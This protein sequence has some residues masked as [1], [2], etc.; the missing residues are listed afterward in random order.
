MAHVDPDIAVKAMSE[1]WC[2]FGNE[3]SSPLLSTWKRMCLA[4]NEAGQRSVGWTVLAMPTG[5]GKTQ[6]AA[7]YCAL[8]HNPALS[9]Y[10]FSTI[11]LHPGVL[12]VTAFVAEAIKFADCVNA[13]AGSNIAAAY[14]KGSPTKLIDAA[15][16]PVLAI[17]HSA[18]ERH[19]AYGTRG[20]NENIVWEQL[21][22]WQQGYRAKIILDERPNFVTPV[23]IKTKEL[24]QTLGAL[25]WLRGANT[26]LYAGIEQL[27]A[28][29][30]DPSSGNRNRRITCSEF[31]CIQSVD[32]DLIL[33]HLNSVDDDALTVDRSTD[34]TSLR[35]TCEKTIEAL[36]QLQANGWGWVS[37]KRRTA[38]LNSAILH[39]SL[40]NGS[41]VVLD[42]T[43]GLNAGYGLLRPAAK[44]VAASPNTRRYD[45]VTLHLAWGHNAG[46]EYLVERADRLWSEYRSA[47]ES[48][49][50]ADDQVLVCCPKEFE[51]KVSNDLAN[52]SRMTFAHWGDIDGRNDWDKHEAVALIGLFYLPSA[53][54][55]NVAQALLG[56]QT[57][58]WLQDSDARAIGTSDDLLV[59]MQ[60]GDLAATAIQAISRVHLRK[61]IDA[62]GHCK[63][64]NVFLAL[65]LGADGRAVLA[66]ILD[67]MPGI[68]IKDWPLN[69][70][71]RK[72]RAAQCS[73][74]LQAFFKG[75]PPG[76]YTK[77]QVREQSRIGATSLDRAIQRMNDPTQS[78]CRC[79][80]DLGVTYQARYGRGAQSFF[81]KA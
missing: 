27:L 42:A 43:A 8:M 52:S 60:R 55:I 38:Q 62:A 30:T 75:A 70:G 14:Y 23:K 2:K 80:I 33:E 56:P 45:N 26:S 3:V 24:T 9:A 66:A 58:H 81:V 37:F 29:I 18:C 47:I 15:H 59:E 40:H 57:D 69:A 64:T 44:V 78:E 76:T 20:T 41:G 16:F 13:L 21:I 19:Q 49:L 53:V 79:L 7:L 32:T 65:P 73:S 54:H 50:P 61:P 67:Y 12:F 10:N 72:P 35:K 51:Y 46:K 71:K 6:F 17:T 11:A 36:E 4:F 39:P 74:Q 34:N 48:V 63:A 1:L 5:I 31:A 77:A 28:T 25:R 22:T 68:Q